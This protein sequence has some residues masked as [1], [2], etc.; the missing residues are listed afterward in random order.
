MPSFARIG[1]SVVVVGGPGEHGSGLWQAHVHTDDPMAAV[2]VGRAALATLRSA[3]ADGEEAA[4]AAAGDDAALRQVRVRHL[5]GPHEE[6]HVLDA[7][8]RGAHDA[9]AVA[10]DAPGLV[11]V[12]TAPGLVADLARAGAVV[13]LRDASGPLDLSA[14]H[15]VAI[16]ARAS[17]VALLPGAQLAED[18][19]A[20]LRATLRDDGV[21]TLEVLPAAT[22]L[23]VAV[24]L[25]AAQLVEP[26]AAQRLEAARSAL[27]AVRWA[28][29][30]AAG[31]PA[32]ELARRL[33]DRLDPLRVHP[34]A[35]VTVLADDDVPG[36]ALEALAT[37][38]AGSGAEVVHLRSG[39]DG[40]AVTLA[41]EGPEA[42]ADDIEAAVEA[43]G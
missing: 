21:R 17:H 20:T 35:L 14:L 24:A 9:A 22:D 32:P 7:A 40:G 37:D 1:D 23:H 34:G 6:G 36:A 11:A 42:A 13:L 25:A 39:R 29:L 8:A 28:R 27:G 26:G 12:T 38:A 19:V 4:P 5:P 41:V 30:D 10:A 33:A 18:D 15:R 2:A 31:R 3:Q 16:D 43:E